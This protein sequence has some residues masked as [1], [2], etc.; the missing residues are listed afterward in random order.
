MVS[1][2]ESKVRGASTD[3]VRPRAKR[4]GSIAVDVSRLPLVVVTFP[5]KIVIDDY[6]DVF[7]RYAQ[8]SQGGAPLVWLVDMRRFDPFQVD[9]LMRKQAARVF[10]KHR[11]ILIEASVAEAR[12]VEGFLT[13]NILTAFDWLTGANKWPCQQ[14]ATVERAEAWLDERIRARTGRG[15]PS[16]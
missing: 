2:G 3:E 12:V 1:A 6:E 4:T 8:I 14:F 16:R 5:P 11:D 15:F 13:R 10:E 9:A 7:E